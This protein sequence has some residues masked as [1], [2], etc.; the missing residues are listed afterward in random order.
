ME[1]KIGSAVLMTESE[2]NRALAGQSRSIGSIYRDRRDETSADTQ[3]ALFGLSYAQLS[4][5]PFCLLFRAC[6]IKIRPPQPSDPRGGFFHFHATTV[7]RPFQA[8]LFFQS[9]RRSGNFFFL[10]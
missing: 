4:F 2:S 3:S 5:S 1:K 8:R 7:R 9:L 6:R 10:R